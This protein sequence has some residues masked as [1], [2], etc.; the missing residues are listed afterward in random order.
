MA[1]SLA[2]EG[3]ETLAVFMYG[4]ENQPKTLVRIPL[5]QF[6]DVLHY[7]NTNI[8]DR[9]PITVVAA[10]KGAEYALNLATK[11]PQISNLI[12]TAPSAYN[13]A[14]LDF[15]NY[16]SSW[17]WE[18]EE[19]PY[20]DIMKS[21]FSVYL[22]NL[23][24]PMII[25]SPIS[26]K[27]TYD[28]A[29]AQDP[30]SKEKLIPVEETDANIMLIVGKEDQMWNSL[31]MAELI[32]CQGSDNIVIHAYN[33]AGHIFNGDGVLEMSDLRIETGGSIE[34]NER[35]NIESIKEINKFLDLYHRR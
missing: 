25:K 24:L 18:G 13:F 7:I 2:R 20:I 17:T 1:E 30:N 19:L 15:N 31:E 28:T 16:G 6:E 27:E 14:G 8:E 29:I 34:A 9:E 11:Y 10:S 3:Y 22:K 5:E 23:L 26:Y 33:G 21:D 12:L 4:M 35:A 32:K